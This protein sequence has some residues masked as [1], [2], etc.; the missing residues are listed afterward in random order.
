MVKRI[1]REVSMRPNTS[2][3]MQ[4]YSLEPYKLFRAMSCVYTTN[5]NVYTLVTCI[6]ICKLSHFHWPYVIWERSKVYRVTADVY[7][8]HTPNLYIR[9][10]R[11]RLQCP[12]FI[13][14]ET[15]IRYINYKMHDKYINNHQL[16]L[17]EYVNKTSCYVWM[18]I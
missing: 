9:L 8:L 3:A 5:G 6:S 10:A 1:Q 17:P 14:W 16:H 11:S 7:T 18:T 4:D 2:K 15:M 12:Y 13:C